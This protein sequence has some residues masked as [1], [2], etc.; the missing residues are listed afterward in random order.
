MSNIAAKI[1]AISFLGVLF[2]PAQ[3]LGQEEEGGVFRDGSRG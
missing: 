2:F 1:L 3:G